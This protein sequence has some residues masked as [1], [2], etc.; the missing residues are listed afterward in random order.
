[1]NTIVTEEKSPGQGQHIPS[2]VVRTEG[3]DR[4]QRAKARVEAIRGFYIHLAIYLLVN[5]CLFAIN[6]LSDP[7]SLWF[8][9]PLLGWGIAVAIHAL[10]VF[11]SV[12]APGSDWEER[13]IREYMNQDR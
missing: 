11:W 1:M 3:Q 9:W 13:K 8:Y 10:T 12:A 2:A 6:M 7:H 4:Y 5:L